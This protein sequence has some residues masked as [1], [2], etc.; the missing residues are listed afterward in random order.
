MS[1]LSQSEILR[2]LLFEKKGDRLYAVLDGASIPKLLLYLTRHRV[3]HVCLYRGELDPELAQTAPYL[4]HLPA[5]SGFTELLLTEGLG[6]HWGVLV[7]S[8]ADLRALRMHFRK[9]LKVW[10]PDGKPLYFRYY[11]PRVLRVYLPTCNAEELSV[12]FGPVSAYFVEAEQADRLLRFTYSGNALAQRQLDLT[13]E[14]FES[15]ED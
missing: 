6:K 14:E 8:K 4:V 5:E 15:R 12:V 13:S 3:D 7:Q 2:K 10:D 1:G 11:D 9:F